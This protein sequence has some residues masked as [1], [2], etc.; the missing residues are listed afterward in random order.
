MLVPKQKAAGV[1]H[2]TEGNQASERSRTGGVLGGPSAGKG[3]CTKGSL[4]LQKNAK[5]KSG[6][7]EAGG[8]KQ[9]SGKIEMGLVQGGKGPATNGPWTL[10][11]IL[12]QGPSRW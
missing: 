7:P 1:K 9:L 4:L 10:G 3:C 2:C 8:L 5:A 11:I 6:F 12:V